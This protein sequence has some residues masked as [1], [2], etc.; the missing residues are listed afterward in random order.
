MKL[1]ALLLSAVFVGA[2]VPPPS[3]ENDLSHCNTKLKDIP[4]HPMCVYRTPEKKVQPTET[5]AGVTQPKAKRLPENTNPRVWELSRANSR[6][7]FNFY[8]Y[9]ANSKSDEENVF[10][11]PLSISTAFAMTKL[12]ACG[13]TLKQ[14]ME[15]FKFDSITEKTSDQVHYFFAKL[16][17]RLYRKAN[18]SS[19][20]V[21]ANRL[22][23]D[24]SLRYNETFQNISEAVYRAKLIPVNFKEK[25][26][27]ARKIINSWVANKTEGLIRDVIPPDA[28]TSLTTLVLVN[29]IYF[30][31]L[32]KSMFEKEL[33]S[34]REF[35]RP[36]NNRCQVPMMQ[37]QGS[38]RFGKFSKDAAKVIELPYKG[39]DVSMV[40]ILPT[41][42][43]SLRELEK[44]LTHE[45]VLGWLSQLRMTDVDLSLPRF[46]VE[47]SFSLTNKLKAM[48]LVDL[49]SPEKANLPGLVEGFHNNFYVSDAFHKAFLEVN[50]E[51]SEAAAASAVMV[52]GRSLRPSLEIF[53]ANQPFLLLIREVAINAI[54]FMGRISDPCVE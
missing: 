49:F 22:F 10:L 43:G 31:G 16:N 20:L 50:E 35:E 3:S 48:G 37:Q 36:A 21:S 5:G 40:L 23:G 34:Q 24:K 17:C 4:G 45:K 27:T 11:S 25:F 26:K 47:D 9:L 52:M 53:N 41:A 54:I 46:R 7:A 38:F 12:G 14:L 28:I 15:V 19:E 44:Q 42:E 8:K 13:D 32:W 39:D 1:L 33:T 18:K 51:G 29:A 6:F 2:I 30:K